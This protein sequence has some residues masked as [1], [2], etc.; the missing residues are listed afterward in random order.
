MIKVVLTG[1]ESTGKTT[2]ARALGAHYGVP[3]SE[4]FVRQ[5]AAKRE[6]PLDFADHGPIARGQMASEDDAIARATTLVVLDTDLL[7]TVIY[8]EHYFGR[9]PAW[10]ED[11]ARNRSGDLYLLMKPDI[12]WVPDG[13][14]DRSDRREEMHALF[15]D[16]LTRRGLR[17]VEVGG[18]SEDRLRMAIEEIEKL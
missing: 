7:S 6:G 2:L 16:A 5:Y 17:F 11:E 13:V 14:R 4:E 10:I 18:S 9:A 15:R 12:P 3:V 1:S 8:C